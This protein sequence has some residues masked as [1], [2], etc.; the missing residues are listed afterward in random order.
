MTAANVISTKATVN[1]WLTV[2]GITAY[3][4]ISKLPNINKKDGSTVQIKQYIG[5]KNNNEVVLYRIWGG[6]HTE[7]SLTEHYKRLYKLIV[8]KQN[9]DFE[10]AEEV[11]KFFERNK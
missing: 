7:P 9:K 10:M 11:W 3:P 2:N 6:G 4:D 5:G 1:Y 8:G